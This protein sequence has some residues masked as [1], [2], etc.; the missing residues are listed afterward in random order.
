[1]AVH[2]NKR[3]GSSAVEPGARAYIGTGN[4]PGVTKQETQA[5][6]QVLQKFCV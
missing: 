3:L 6:G 2:D 4:S 1:M 5:S